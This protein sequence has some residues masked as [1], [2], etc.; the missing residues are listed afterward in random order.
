MDDSQI[1]A[2]AGA[3][4]DLR[5][6]PLA[7][8]RKSANQTCSLRRGIQKRQGVIEQYAPEPGP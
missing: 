5:L 8:Q 2:G 1:S 4:Q 6:L 3:L 7:C